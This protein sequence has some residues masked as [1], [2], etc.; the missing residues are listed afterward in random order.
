VFDHELANLVQFRS[1]GAPVLSVYFDVPADPG[2]LKG[3]HARVHSLLKPIH[4]V[5]ASDELT[6]AA[7]ESLRA[8][9]ARLE[10]LGERGSELLGRGVAA[11]AC[12]SEGLYEEVVLAR[13]F[14]ER[15]VVD[16]TPYLRPLLSTVAQAR[17]YLVVVV[18]R[19]RSWFFDLLLRE[20][21]EATHIIAPSTQR[22]GR[23]SQHDADPQHVENR[24]ETLSRKHYHATGEAA[25]TLVQKTGAERLIVGGHHETVSAFVDMAPKSLRSRVVGTFVIDPNTMTP[26]KVRECAQPVID[27]YE[28]TERTQLVA[29]AYERVNA[30]GNAAIGIG[31]CL[32]ATNESA[33]DTLLIH[34]DSEVPGQVCDNC[35]WLGL[36]GDECPVDGRPTRPTPDVID[37]TAEAVLVAGGR[38]EQ[39]YDDS[40][41]ANDVVAALLRFPV[42][43]PT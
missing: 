22:P 7:R 4:D 33:V 8:D 16:E 14:P 19:G 29:T 24:A 31:W 9:I 20:V 34:D 37:E 18:E 3:V 30:R 43:Q 41:L 32:L 11:F 15:A 39:V 27:D 12:S 42:V 28:R 6:H 2:E 1:T 26:A 36:A 40:P 35:G 13:E 21:D 23:P 10:G 17:R 25:A 5:V 38:V